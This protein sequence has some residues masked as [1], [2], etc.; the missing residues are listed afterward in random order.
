MQLEVPLSKVYKDLVK[1]LETGENREAVF[2]EIR[3]V[4]ENCRPLSPIMCV[5]LCQIWRLK[6]ENP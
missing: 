4:C 2:M 3:E 1:K 6:R 5:E